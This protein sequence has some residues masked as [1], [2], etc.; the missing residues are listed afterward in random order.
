MPEARPMR[1]DAARNRAKIMEAANRQIMARGPEVPMESIAED[2]GVAVGTLYRHFPTKQDLVVAVLEQCFGA[3]REAAEAAGDRVE[4]GASAIVEF[5]AFARIVM[6]EAASNLAMKAAARSLGADYHED[7]DR[8]RGE[9]AMQRLID[10]AKAEGTVR[11]DLSLED[12]QLFFVTVPVDQP[13][14]VRERWFDLMIDGFR[15]GA[16]RPAP[17]AA[18]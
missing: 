15:A 17:S 3:L 5:T 10:A 4:A 6:E 18:Q 12:C 11:P 8:R 7:E 14:A 9:A 13:P 16:A 1:A 2:A